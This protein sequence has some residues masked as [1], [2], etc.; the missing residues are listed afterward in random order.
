MEFYFKALIGENKIYY[1][2]RKGE[3]ESES[4]RGA[5]EFDEG[6]VAIGADITLGV[7]D[8]T[9]GLAELDELL[10]RALPWE[11]PE[12]ENLRRRLGVPELGRP[13]G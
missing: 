6:L 8:L 5:Y 7:D 3:L 4:E 12:V 11:I 13:R 9:E 2:K 1:G 10:F